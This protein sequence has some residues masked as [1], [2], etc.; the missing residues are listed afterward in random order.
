MAAP[1]IH[2][3]QQLGPGRCI[4]IEGQ[5]ATHVIQVL[6]LRPGAVLHVFDGQGHE[7]SATLLESRRAR[8]SL[9]LHDALPGIPES[10]LDITLVQGIARHDRMDLILQKAVELGVNTIQPLWMQRSQSRLAGERLDKRLHHWAGVI[11]SAC[12][13]CGRNTLPELRA[14]HPFDHWLA[15][16]Q[17]AALKLMLQ[18]GSDDTLPSLHQPDGEILLLVGPEGGLNPDEQSMAQDAGFTGVRLGQRVL[19]TETAALAAIAGMQVLWGDY[20]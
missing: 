16:G 9:E 17:P 15:A 7:F 18:P 4:D 3:A 12:E 2:T 11:V 10:A 5:A 6:R 8:I 14:P 19:R 1:R 13:Q 20:R